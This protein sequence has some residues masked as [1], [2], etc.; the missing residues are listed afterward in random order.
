MKRTYE[1]D[2]PSE[3]ESSFYVERATGFIYEAKL[4]A[5]FVVI[6]PA[7]PEASANIMRIP[8]I[9][10]AHTFTDYLGDHDVIRRYLWGDN[11]PENIVVDKK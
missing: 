5:D 9:D 7:T 1:E 3:P 2:E 4:F 11:T 8:L 10:F 6:R